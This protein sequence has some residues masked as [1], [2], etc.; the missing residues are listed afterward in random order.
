[1]KIQKLVP[2]IVC[3]ICQKKLSKSSLVVMV[4]N[5]TVI[6]SNPK[7]WEKYF[8]HE[9]TVFPKEQ[10]ERWGKYDSLFRFT[11]D[12]D[13]SSKAVDRSQFEKYKKLFR[14]LFLLTDSA[15]VQPIIRDRIWSAVG[16]KYA[17]QL[18][19]I[20]ALSRIYE[21][22]K[23]TWHSNFKKTFIPSVLSQFKSKGYLSKKQWLVVEDLVR[24][25]LDDEDREYYRRSVE[26]ALEIS[27]L[28]LPDRLR[29]EQRKRSFF[30]WYNAKN[31][32]KEQ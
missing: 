30:R 25:N 23:N 27:N 6:H 2:G 32:I 29:Y 5:R 7:C 17:R 8:T 13:K 22:N 28:E 1:M 4:D 10:R 11:E 9:Q 16:R 12:Y 3:P 26:N 24:Q 20:H 21:K 19:D 18:Q 31:G 14:R 15:I